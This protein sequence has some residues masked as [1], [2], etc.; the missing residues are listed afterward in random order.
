MPAEPRRPS[1]LLLRL[2]ARLILPGSDDDVERSSSASIEEVKE[3]K[4]RLERVDRRDHR[5]GAGGGRVA[6]FLGGMAH[7]IGTQLRTE[8]SV[9]R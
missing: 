4:E 9:P 6:S 8:Y 7:K 5:R 1:L 2:L 3:R